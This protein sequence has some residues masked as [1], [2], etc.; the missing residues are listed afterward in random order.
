MFCDPGCGPAFGGGWDLQVGSTSETPDGEF[1]DSSFACVGDT[2]ED[3][4]D[5][6]RFTFTGTLFFTP[7]EVEV[8]LVV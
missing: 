2:Y 8:Y 3:V 5:N 1:D 6:G 4:L 7:V